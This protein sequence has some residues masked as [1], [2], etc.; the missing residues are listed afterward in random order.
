MRPLASVLL[1][2]ALVLTASGCILE[3]NDVDE[4]L[5]GNAEIFTRRVSFDL[6]RATLA[7]GTVASEQ[8]SIPAI[9]PIVV[10]EG[11]VLAYYRFAGTWTALPYTISV[12]APDDPPRVDYSATFSYAYD[13][14]LLEVFV[15]SSSSDPVVWDDIADT[16]LF[17][18]PVEIKVVIIN[19][20]PF[21]S[22]TGELNLRDYEAV[23]AFYGLED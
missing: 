5:I 7:D 17:R 15:E 10:D 13:D 21:A 11:T 22:K 6:D 20:L 16:D 9:T 4:D 8:Y 19:S 1:L 23:K 18:A 2:A 3:A 14:G 12:E